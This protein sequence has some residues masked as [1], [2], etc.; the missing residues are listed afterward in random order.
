MFKYSVSRQRDCF[1]NEKLEKRWIEGEPIPTLDNGIATPSLPNISRLIY[2]V[3]GARYNRGA[4]LRKPVTCSALPR[5][6][7]VRILHVYVYPPPRWNYSHVS[8]W[9]AYTF[10][11][12]QQS[13]R[14]VETVFSFP[15]RRIE[16]F[17]FFLNVLFAIPRSIGKIW[18]ADDVLH[19]LAYYVCAASSRLVCHENKPSLP[20]QVRKI[21][22][23]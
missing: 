16:N 15:I 9:A 1:R 18:L 21:S 8:R 3:V 13:I 10:V 7:P 12:D 17:F 20:R 6:P 23:I 22:F 19:V 5:T 11:L 14:I 2:G 4:T